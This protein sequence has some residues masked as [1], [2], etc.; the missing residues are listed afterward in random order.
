M[1]R[2]VARVGLIL[3]I[4]MAII[5]SGASA[6]QLKVGVVDINTVIS[7]S[8]AGKA[9]NNNLAR[10]VE[11]LRAELNAKQ[12]VIDEL[13]QS[14]EGLDEAE[15]SAK[16][17]EIEQLEAEL[18]EAA[19]KAQQDVDNLTEEYRKILLEDIGKVLAIVAEEDGYHLIVDAATTYYYANLL[20]ITWEVIR[21]YNDLYEQALQSV[22]QNQ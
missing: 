19:A 9:L 4:L 20:D 2:F 3:L 10:Y 8:D 17:A 12:Q 7:Q 11:S 1:T 5:V 14:L 13:R 15:K 6:A 16:Q 22:Q 18:R 21:K